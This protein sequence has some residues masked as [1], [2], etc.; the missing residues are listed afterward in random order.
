[1]YY[2]EIELEQH[3]GRILKYETFN[4]HYETGRLVEHEGKYWL[5]FCGG[6]NAKTVKIFVK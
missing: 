1:M 3:V 6:V 5:P 4:N 2:T